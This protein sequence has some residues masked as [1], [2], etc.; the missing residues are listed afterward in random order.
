MLVGGSE[1]ATTEAMANRE[2]IEW[3]RA[4]H[5][6]TQWTKARVEMTKRAAKARVPLDV[7]TSLWRLTLDRMRDRAAARR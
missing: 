3:L 5:L 6:T 4:V 7:A 2:L 1:A